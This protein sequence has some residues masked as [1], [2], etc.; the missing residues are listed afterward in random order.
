MRG[1]GFC[2]LVQSTRHNILF[3]PSCIR[4]RELG[5]PGN[6]IDLFL[7]PFLLLFAFCSIV[8]QL[9]KLT[10]VSESMVEVRWGRI[11]NKAIMSEIVWGIDL[12]KHTISM[13][14]YCNLLSLERCYLSFTFKHLVW[15]HVVMLPLSASVLEFAYVCMYL[16]VVSSVIRTQCVQ[17]FCI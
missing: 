4:C 6:K 15:L 14:W 2:I 7:P 5:L 10:F 13:S 9:N 11:Q 12:S 3:F 1:W 8:H 16:I 17:S